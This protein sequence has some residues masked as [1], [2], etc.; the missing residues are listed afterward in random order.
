VIAARLQ[1]PDTEP[2]FSEGQ[3]LALAASLALSQRELDIVRLVFE[4]VEEQTI[5]GQFGTSVNTVRTQLKR[6]YWKLGV[7]SR[8]GL[9]LRIVREHLDNRHEGEHLEPG[10]R[11]HH[12]ARKAA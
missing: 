8:V 4:D 2:L 6:L 5:A 12:G 9:V 7:R 3:W 11:L 10:L 1:F